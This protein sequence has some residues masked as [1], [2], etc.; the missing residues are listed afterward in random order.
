MDTRSW[1]RNYTGV[2]RGLKAKAIPLILCEAK[3][4]NSILFSKNMQSSSV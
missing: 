4:K 2:S 1:T 3:G